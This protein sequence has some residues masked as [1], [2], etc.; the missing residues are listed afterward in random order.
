MRLLRLILLSLGVMGLFAQS[1]HAGLTVQRIEKLSF[2]QVL[3]QPD[4]APDP[5]KPFVRMAVN[6]F[7]MPNHD[8]PIILRTIET[9]ART[10]GENNFE[11]RVI[12]DTFTV[13]ADSQ[14]VL[15]SAGTFARARITGS[16]DVATLV[17]RLRPDP[18][19]GEG[20]LFLTLRS[21]P[22]RSFEDM[23]GK[24]AAM[25]GARAFTGRVTALGEMLRRGYDPDRFF[26]Q[27]LYTVDSMPEEIRLLRSGAV[28]VAVVRTCFLEEIGKGYPVEDLAVIGARQSGESACL[29]STD[30]YP[31][32]TVFVTP[33]A[34]PGI[35][36][37]ATVALLG[38][39][40][41]DEG[42]SWSVASDFTAVDS[43]YRNLR[44]G[45][46]AYLRSFSMMRFWEEYREWII[47]AIL[48][49]LGLIAHGLRSS[50]LVEKRTAELKVAIRVQQE[51]DERARKAT[52]RME[53]LQKLGLIGQMS[54]IFAHELRQPLSTITAYA[55]GLLRALDRPGDVNREILE[56]GLDRIKGQAL[57]ADGIVQKVRAY[58]R[59]PE[60]SRAQ[61][62]LREVVSGACATVL[63]AKSWNARFKKTLGEQPAVV[64]GDRMELEL[65]VLN[66]V[67]NALEAAAQTSEGEVEVT[68][69]SDQNR[70][71]LMVSDNGP[72]ISDRDFAR[73]SEPLSSSK[74]DGTGLGVAI[75]RMV[76][77]KHQGSVTFVRRDGRG[78]E[79]AVDLPAGREED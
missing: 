65:L 29:T 54:T 49:I 2:D 77:E 27:E 39:K 75:V 22:I 24:R 35:A 11:A 50:A 32:W 45:P 20:S 66:L 48:M 33:R 37:A 56:E 78:L 69:A 36:K 47:L 6:I 16:R 76:A 26:S 72:A 12:P 31:N 74:P 70:I 59:R 53:T 17:S 61:L 41:D 68:L 55:S 34:T 71:R 8:A 18:N 30:L 67:K 42:R 7:S 25:L 51:A 73:L 43:L 40:A 9:L 57:A 19:H 64:H 58:A 62:D 4:G 13:G 15:G 23:K 52:E 14:I 44:M 10:F 3:W 60:A 38:M 1:A 63:A 28:D 21:S 5:D 46:Y 79:A